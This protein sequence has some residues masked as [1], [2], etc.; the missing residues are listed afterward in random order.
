MATLRTA[1]GLAF[2]LL[3]PPHSTDARTPAERPVALI[4][5]WCCDRSYLAP[6]AEHLAQSRTVVT[7][8]LRGHGESA[9]SDEGAYA[10][11]DFADDVE[12]VLAASSVERAVAVGHSLGGVV[13]VE[14][15]ARGSVCGAVLLDPAP[16]VSARGRQILASWGDQVAGDHDGRARRS[17]VRGLFLPTDTARC[18][19]IVE[20]MSCVPVEVAGPAMRLMATYDAAARLREVRVPI[21]LVN[22]DGAQD[23][24]PIRRLCP[25]LMTAQ[26]AGSGH[27]ITLE[28]PEQVNA[29]LDRFLTVLER[30]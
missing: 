19:E 22:S 28:V 1:S 15:A 17:I 16:L 12:E 26:T 23:I 30:A 9:P 24:R 2:E 27:F 18:E 5:G 7:L 20:A 11:T 25:Q 3:E 13:A 8:D 10:I 14:L 4:H 6:Q 21:L 29:M